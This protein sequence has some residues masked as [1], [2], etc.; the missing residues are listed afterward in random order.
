VI[1]GELGIA[2][3]AA[4]RVPEPIAEGCEDIG[5]A[6]IRDPDPIAGLCEVIGGAA[7]RDPDPTEGTKFPPPTAG[8][9]ERE[10][11]CAFACDRHIKNATGKANRLSLFISAN[12]KLKG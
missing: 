10:P 9:A 11:D 7:I 2:P 3:G 4:I 8:A 12:S 1:T 5:G 6:A